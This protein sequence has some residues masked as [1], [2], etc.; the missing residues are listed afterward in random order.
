MSESNRKFERLPV[1][2]D[3]LTL[4]MDLISRLYRQQVTRIEHGKLLEEHDPEKAD[5]IAQGWQGALD[6]FFRKTS[7]YPTAAFYGSCNDVALNPKGEEIMAAIVQALVDANI[8]CLNGCARVGWMGK[9]NQLVRAAGARMFHVPLRWANGQSKEARPHEDE[10]GRHTSPP[11]ATFQTRTTTLQ[12]AGEVLIALY[13][14]GGVGT[15]EERAVNWLAIQ[16]RKW[17]ITAFSDRPDDA[18]PFQIFIDRKLP[19]GV[20]F[21]DGFLLELSNM[22]TAQTIKPVDISRFR[23]VR[24]GDEDESP[25]SQLLHADVRACISEFA[26]AEEAADLVIELAWEVYQALRQYYQ[27]QLA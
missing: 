13:N 16:L 3:R 5:A 6:R 9:V 26:T 27:A 17:T 4:F 22:L 12:L 19:N 21:W 23:I 14:E 25:V 2:P 18:I 7:G 20:W 8:V 10:R 11:H 15:S 24:V 1:F